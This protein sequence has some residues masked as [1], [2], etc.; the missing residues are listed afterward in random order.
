MTNQKHIDYWLKSAEKDWEIM[1]Y[2]M[3]GGKYVYSLFFWHLYLE[4]LTKALWVKNNDE[5][6]PPKIHNLL[7]LLKDA[8]IEITEEQQLFIL[9]LNKYQIEGRYPEDIEKLH[10]FTNKKLSEEYVK[11]IKELKKCFLKR[12]L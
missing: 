3:K 11:S 2:L 1:E 7:K 4:K 8:E 9:K 6:V 5:N 10:K 12:M